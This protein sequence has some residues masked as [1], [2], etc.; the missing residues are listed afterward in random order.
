MFAMF[1]IILLISSQI[2]MTYFIYILNCCILYFPSPV[3][4]KDNPPINFPAQTVIRFF[5]FPGV[6]F[7]FIHGYQ[8]FTAPRFLH[9]CIWNLRFQF[10]TS[11]FSTHSS[12][13]TICVLRYSWILRLWLPT[14]LS[15]LQLIL[16]TSTFCETTLNHIWRICRN[17][18]K[19]IGRANTG[20]CT[21][22]AVFT[23]IV[24]NLQV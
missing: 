22:V 19:C 21:F 10:A 20:N 7:H 23:S 17:T 13:V 3:R 9:P 24:T 6:P 18:L 12:K 16:T 8:T 11:Y 1:L 4:N 5:S 2:V 14:F 15:F